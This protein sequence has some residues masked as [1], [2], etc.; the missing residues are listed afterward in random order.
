MIP[1]VIIMNNKGGVIAS[2]LVGQGL[3]T[4]FREESQGSWMV[5]WYEIWAEKWN[6][7]RKG[8]FTCCPCLAR[9]FFLV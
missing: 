8:P 5:A 3:Q 4:V 9:Y 6:R 2:R 7:A 1:V